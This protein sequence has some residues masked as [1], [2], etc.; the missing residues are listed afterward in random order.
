MNRLAGRPSPF[1]IHA[2]VLLA[3]AGCTLVFLHPLSLHLTA[4]LTDPVDPLLNTWIAAWDVHAL[5]TAPHRLFDAN[6]FHAYPDALAYSET[7]LGSVLLIFPLALGLGLPVLSHNLILFSGFILGGYT[8]YL[9]GRFITRSHWA[10]FLVGLIFIFNGYRLSMLPKVQMETLQWLPLAIYYLWRTAQ[11]GRWRDGFMLAGFA[12]FQLI[13]TIYYGVFSALMLALLAPIMLLAHRDRWP[14]KLA[15][16]LVAGGTS[17]V[18]ALLYLRPYRRLNALFGL[19]RTLD[20]A[21]PFAAS[22]RQWMMTSPH[23]WLYG[24]WLGLSDP[25]MVG[26]YPVDFLFPGLL[27]LILA[28][29]G[30]FLTRRAWLGWG[31]AV[32]LT[33][34]AFLLSLGPVLMVEPLKPLVPPVPLPY[35]WLYA[36]LP[37]FEAL[38]APA[39]FAGFVM[40]GLG[41]LAGMTLAF[42][43]RRGLRT[44]ILAGLVALVFFESLARPATTLIA[45]PQGDA[46]PPVYTWLRTQP[47]GVVVDLPAAI[48]QQSRLPDRWLWPQYY[49]I[50]HWNR[51]PTGY[52][53]FVPPR[54]ESL[55]DLLN[56]F[57]ED[58][59]LPLYRALD[60]RYVILHRR[61]FSQST[62]DAVIRAV[63]THPDMTLAWR[64]ED[65]MVITLAPA[66]EIPRVVTGEI[67]LPPDAAT[68]AHF[69]PLLVLN[70]DPATR[71][72][73]PGDPAL[74]EVIW[75][76]DG[77]VRHRQPF[78]AVLPFL[79]ETTTA[80][81]LVFSPPGP[82]EYQVTIHITHPLD[83]QATGR[84]RIRDEAPSTQ[85][86]PM[87]LTHTA[88]TCRDQ[89]LTIQQTWVLWGWVDVPQTLSV[90]LF[91]DEGQKIAQEDTPLTPPPAQWLLR[92]PM[93]FT[94]TLAWP[95]G[96]SPV[97]LQTSLYA[98]SDRF[99]TIIPA[100]YFDPNGQ[101]RDAVITAIT[102]PGCRE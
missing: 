67:L 66:T 28:G 12:T 53:G 31:V 73:P 42:L 20:D 33:G 16:L 78:A 100:Q 74:G 83:L 11:R 49:S 23:H 13:T 39:R 45:V 30:L 6:I 55:I 54:H 96:T 52:S 10:A 32:L 19:E 9:L 56:R 37:G 65:A 64:D 94:H 44:W 76:Q 25:P 80:T 26:P 69:A 99:Q 102:G 72:F 101:L 86:L 5:L 4:T 2:W 59:V 61:Y 98:W 3:Y 88:M 95:A 97:R 51:T 15:V 34:M 70:L 82:G 57:P 77:R 24:R 50:Y 68:E 29:A 75:E 85:L 48:P 63:Q 91:D 90:Q 47:P 92:Q 35:A 79:A 89:E 40:L 46:I 60:V 21:I 43:Q 62:W 27:V 7:L 22:L 17:L 1:R 18:V 71:A 93:T 87:Q 81:N 38:R 84:V 58:T 14:R 8:A 36:H 41:L